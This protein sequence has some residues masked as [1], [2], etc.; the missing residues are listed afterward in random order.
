MYDITGVDFGWGACVNIHILICDMC[1]GQCVI[2]MN[3]TLIKY[4][5]N[6]HSDYNFTFS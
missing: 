2:N 5:I 1:I 6:L 3:E 4:V